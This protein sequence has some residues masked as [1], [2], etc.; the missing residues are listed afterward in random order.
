MHEIDR[1]IIDGDESGFVK[2]HVRDG[3]D[4]IL[5]AT[6][7]ARHA[8]DM[9]NGLSLAMVAGIGLSTIA[10]VIHAYPT[11][12]DAI[13]QA[14]KAHLNMPPSRWKTMLRRWWFSR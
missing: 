6:V 9:I 14:A 3:S 12:T 1:A 13:R 4:K 8:G 5:G 11:Q 2:I 10:Q 7:V